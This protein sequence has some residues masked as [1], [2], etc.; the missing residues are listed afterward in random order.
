MGV[1]RKVPFELASCEVGALAVIVFS[2]LSE[3]ALMEREEQSVANNGDEQQDNHDR[4]ISAPVRLGTSL[5]AVFV[6][7]AKVSHLVDS[8]QSTGILNILST[9]RG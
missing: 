3:R 5:A 7:T 1:G 8:S 4:K 2:D 6:G 9:R